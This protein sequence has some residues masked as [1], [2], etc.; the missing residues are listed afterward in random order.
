MLKIASDLEENSSVGAG[1]GGKYGDLQIK[2]STDGVDNSISSH[3]GWADG[4][5]DHILNEDLEKRVKFSN[6]LK[7]AI[8]NR[9]DLLVED[10]FVKKYVNVGAL[11][12]QGMKNETEENNTK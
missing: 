9:N 10:L 6:L 4:V 1:Y 7:N 12:L 8:N 11:P 3:D 5:N 2:L